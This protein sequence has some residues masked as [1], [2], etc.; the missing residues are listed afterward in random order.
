[1]LSAELKTVEQLSSTD[2]KEQYRL[3][4]HYFARTS[5]PQFLQD[6][7]EKQYVILLKDSRQ[8][9]Q[10]FSTVVVMDFITA[11]QGGKAMFSGDTIIHKQFWGSQA[12]PLSWC[13]LAGR[14]KRHS[15][16]APLYWFLIVKG[17]RTY[18]YLNLFANQYYP[19][20][21]CDTPTDVQNIMDHLALKKFG[22]AYLKQKG[23]VHYPQSR[24]HLSDEW[25]Q[26]PNHVASKPEVAYFLKA[27]PNYTK[28]DELVCLTLLNE[29]N[30]KSHAKRAF[31]RGFEESI[32]DTF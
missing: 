11:E 14:I 26:I 16:Q 3:L 8:M 5:Y 7:S 32:E 17:Y 27:N 9:I 20:W 28:G 24:G 15:I 10:G 4:R 21:D 2:K 29:S 19:H 6:L 31:L 13:R 23:I 1:M 30:L 12:L 18:R 22:N 25:A